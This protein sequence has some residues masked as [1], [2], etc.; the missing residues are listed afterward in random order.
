LWEIR[1]RDLD[2]V[3]DFFG[4]PGASLGGGASGCSLASGAVAGQGEDGG[5]QVAELVFRGGGAVSAVGAG[6]V[7]GD[8]GADQGEHGG[9]R[10]E[11]GAGACFCGGAG[12]G[13]RDDV[14]DEQQRPGLLAGEFWGVAAQRPAGASDGFLQVEERDFSQPPL[15]PV[16]NKWSLAF[17]RI[18]GRY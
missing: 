14:V 13:G 16:K 9:E 6:D 5:V 7:G 12:G 17:R 4:S 11:A 1:L 10:D 15:M 18:P 2:G 3:G 8:V